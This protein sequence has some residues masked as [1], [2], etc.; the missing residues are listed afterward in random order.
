MSHSEDPGDGARL[1]GWE[2]EVDPSEG[3]GFVGRE[4]QV[5]GQAVGAR[6]VNRSAVPDDYPTTIDTP[7]ALAI[8]FRV[9]DHV[10]D[11]PEPDA[12]HAPGVSPVGLWGCRQVV[13][14]LEGQQGGLAVELCELVEP[15]KFE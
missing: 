4:L 13:L 1:A 3:L 2:G 10:R 9:D 7:R 5:R 15:L 8:Q 6:I 14:P 11:E 12:V